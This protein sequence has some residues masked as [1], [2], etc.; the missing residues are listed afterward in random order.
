MSK[1]ERKVSK[2]EAKG[3]V[4]RHLRYEKGKK[5]SFSHLAE[6]RT[7]NVDSRMP[8]IALSE[9]CIMASIYNAIVY[10][11]LFKTGL[12]EFSAE[13]SAF[14]ILQFYFSMR[15][16]CKTSVKNGIIGYTPR[17]YTYTHQS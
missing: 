6:R 5:G 16:A 11:K 12:L 1:E 9:T 8:S 2:K 15:K 3:S 17:K 4:N 14:C 13:Y 7:L 10:K